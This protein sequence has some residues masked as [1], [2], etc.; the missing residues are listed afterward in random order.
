MSKHL[1]HWIA[2]QGWTGAFASP[3]EDM[4]DGITHVI[5]G[6]D[7]ISNTPTQINILS[8]L[9]AELPVYAHVPDVL[10]DDGTISKGQQIRYS[11]Q[12]VNKRDGVELVGQTPTDP[13]GHCLAQSPRSGSGAGVGAT[14]AQGDGGRARPERGGSPGACGGA[15]IAMRISMSRR[16]DALWRPI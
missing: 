13:R 10:G 3:V 16:G 12:K 9:G 1:S 6:N 7:H 5:R 8:A 2:G 4:L 15:E 11:P 14:T